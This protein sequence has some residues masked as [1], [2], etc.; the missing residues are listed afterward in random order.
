MKIISL[1][2]NQGRLKLLGN[3]LDNGRNLELQLSNFL[4]LFG[5]RMKK[6]I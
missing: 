4:V 1:I 2:K 6:L 5:K 3:N